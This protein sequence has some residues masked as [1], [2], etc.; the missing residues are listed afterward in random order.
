MNYYSRHVGDYITKTLHL[1]LMEHG[2]YNRL[3]DIYYSTEKPIPA[4]LV[5]VC[6]M[7]PTR[8]A[9]EE[10]VVENILNLFFEMKK[11][12]W[13]Q[14]RCDREIADVVSSRNNGKK[15]GRPKKKINLEETQE[16]PKDNLDCNLNQTFPFP[17]T[18][19][20]DK[21]EPKGSKEKKLHGCMENV[22]LTDAEYQKLVERFGADVAGKKIDACSLYL[23]SKGDK[24]KNHYAT[25][26]SWAR[27]DGTD[28]L[29]AN[30]MD[31]SKIMHPEE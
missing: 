17:I 23:A 8:S 13:H 25:I 30:D 4:D 15:G 3:L 12:G 7:I 2:A 21:K 24:Y 20:P 27:K 29:A 16:K 11:D 28:A 1:N 31:I 10:K 19:I 9:E 5:L 26:L 14:Q 18:H 22:K 6:R